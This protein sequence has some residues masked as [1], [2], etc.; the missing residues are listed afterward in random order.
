MSAEVSASQSS[1]GLKVSRKERDY[2][3]RESINQQ[4][5]NSFQEL[6]RTTKETEE[7]RKIGDPRRAMWE[8]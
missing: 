8:N 2:I 5:K 6:T 1:T 7:V 4:W 3:A